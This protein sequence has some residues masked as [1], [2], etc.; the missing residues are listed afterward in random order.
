VLQ[1]KEFQKLKGVADTT[2]M[3]NKRPV[4]QINNR[5]LM[6]KAGASDLKISLLLIGIALVIS[7]DAVSHK[8]QL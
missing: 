1:L 5:K 4:Q 8:Q 3:E 6:Y 2:I 7:Q